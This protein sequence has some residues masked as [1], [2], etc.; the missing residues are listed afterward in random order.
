MRTR[1]EA[2]G[3]YAALTGSS[4]IKRG[5]RRLRGQQETAASGYV[6]NPP[7]GKRG[8]G[9]FEFRVGMLRGYFTVSVAEPDILPPSFALM[10]VLPGSP[11]STRPLSFFALLTLATLLS[12]DFQT[13]DRVTSRVMP[14]E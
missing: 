4:E 9:K 12:E 7:F 11:A 10:V 1:L 8:D 2:D 6:K 14:S 13:A 5:A 3:R